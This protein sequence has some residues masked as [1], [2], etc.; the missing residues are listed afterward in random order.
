MRLLQDGPS[1]DPPVEVFGVFFVLW[2]LT[3][4]VAITLLVLAIIITVRAYKEGRE[5]WWIYL[6]AL[7]IS[8]GP[9]VIVIAW[10]AYLRNNPVMKDGKPFL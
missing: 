6:I 9:L 3:A 4:A 2:I 10:Y 1:I 5:G 8:P 7:F